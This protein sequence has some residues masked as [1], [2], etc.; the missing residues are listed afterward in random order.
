[1]PN[2]LIESNILFLRDSLEVVLTKFVVAIIILLIG[3]II[4]KLTGKIIQWALHEIE[5]NNLLQKA[6][7][8]KVSLEEIASSFTSYFIYFTSLI[9]AL[10]H[11]G[12]TTTV[13]NI[14]AASIIIIV[15]IS[16]FLSI[17]DFIPNMIAGIFIHQKRIINTGDIIKVIDVS[18]KIIHI[19]LVETMVETKDKD[20]IYI[21]NSMLTKNVIRIAKKG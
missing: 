21:P 13:L 9:M 11:V 6:I 3:F 8:I 4:G 18:G 2:N 1:M 19:N 7:G 14:V 15:I 17:K 5:L 12:L 10:S 20:I 16:V